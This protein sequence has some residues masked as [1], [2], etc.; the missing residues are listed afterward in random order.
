MVINRRLV[1][2]RLARAESMQFSSGFHHD[3]VSGLDQ[4]KPDLDDSEWMLDLGADLGFQGFEL[5][6]DSVCGRASP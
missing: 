2:Y 6:G 1:M 5:I 3:I 4:F